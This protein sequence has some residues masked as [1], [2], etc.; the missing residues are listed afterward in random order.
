MSSRLEPIL[1]FT[2]WSNK[3]SVSLLPCFTFYVNGVLR[4]KKSNRLLGI[5]RA[6][7]YESILRKVQ[8]MTLNTTRV[9]VFY[10]QRLWRY[11]SF[12]QMCTEWPQN[13]V[14]HY[15]VKGTGY[16]CYCCPWVSICN[17]FRCTTN[18]LALRKTVFQLQTIKESAPN[19]PKMTLNTTRSNV[20]SLYVSS[21]H[22][23]WLL[24]YHST[25][26]SLEYLLL[27]YGCG[28]PQSHI[29]TFFY[30][31]DY[32]SNHIYIT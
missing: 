11:G 16:M 29:F 22:H 19:D 18:R 26:F 20:H 2:R 17:T 10:G 13:D 5:K 4:R 14:E 6:V 28:S 21:G 27:S 24:L 7:I 8:W 30:M 3:N 25:P 9:P 32:L 12:W 1:L 15:K 23:A 31:K